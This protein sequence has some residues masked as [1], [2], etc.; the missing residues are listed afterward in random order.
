MFLDRE[1]KKLRV[2]GELQRVAIAATVLREGDF[3]YF[4]EPTSWLDVSQRLN[5]VK[6]IRSL[7]QDGKKCF[8]Y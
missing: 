3:Y 7:A 8:S 4:D 5:A 1:M 2:A 6:V